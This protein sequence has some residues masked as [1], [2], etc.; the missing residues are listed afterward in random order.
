MKKF[1]V[2][3]AITVGTLT[4]SLVLGGLY[5]SKV[6][7]TNYLTPH[8]HD[9]HNH[10]HAE[11]K[12]VNNYLQ[13]KNRDK[14]TVCVESFTSEVKAED[15]SK[16]TLHE[17]EKSLKQHP[18]WNVQGLD[19]FDIEV[20]AGCSFDPILL[21]PGKKHVFY[22]GDLDSVRRVENASPERVG[23]FIVND[24]VI[25]K[26]FEGAPAR[27]APEEFLYEEGEGYLEVTT[28]VYLT[29]EDLSSDKFSKELKFVLGLD[30][31]PKK[32]KN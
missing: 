16:K 26:H 19:K 8:S 17:I 9:A 13:A 7:A 21:E 2:T 24:D 15:I 10:S 30:I 14:L 23:I 31:I 29:P 20:K 32:Q 1:G 28:G 12:L 18:R 27:M 6:E 4:L 22:S 3:K 11:S 25:N 5:L